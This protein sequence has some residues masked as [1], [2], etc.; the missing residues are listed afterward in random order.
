M[1]EL[2]C[3]H[4]IK[5]VEQVLPGWSLYQWEEEGNGERVWESEYGTNTVYTH[6]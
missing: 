2:A 1:F 4:C 3:T 6:M 5:W